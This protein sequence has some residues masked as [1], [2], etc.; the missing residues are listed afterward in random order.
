MTITRR[1]L[2][3][4]SIALF[5]LVVVSAFGLRSLGKAQTRFESVQTDTVP[6]IIDL[7]TIRNDFSSLRVNAYREFLAITDEQRAELNDSRQAI[8]QRLDRELAKYEATEISD[9][10][11][12]RMLQVDR[13]GLRAYETA[14]TTM[15]AKIHAGDTEAAKKLILPHGDMAEAA[16][17]LQKALSDHIDYNQKLGENLRQENT[18]AYTSTVTV[19]SCIVV[20][21]VLT[22]GAL[23]AQLYLIISRGLSGL[24]KTLED[25]SGS[26]DLT[27]TAPVVRMDEIGHTSVAF[28]AL[29]ARVA[30]VVGEVRQSSGSV[31]VASREI[32]A[33]NIDLSAR[34]E[35]Q[36]ASL[37]QTAA[38]M[39]QLT[40]TVKQNTDSAQMASKLAGDA[41]DVT[42]AGSG[43]VKRMVG[44]MNEITENSTKI[45]DITA[46]IE[47]IA[48]QTNILALNAAVEA[49][50]AGEQ[51]RGFAV[52]ASEV[53]TLAQRSSAAA[54]EIKDLIAVS[55]SVVHDGS[56]QAEEVGRV[57]VQVGEAVKRVADIIG[58]IA[59]ASNEQSRG[60]EQVNQAVAQMD[61]VTQQNAAL[62]EE[63]A[64]ATQSLQE[65]ANKMTD[66]VSAFRVGG[67]HHAY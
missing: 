13:D 5:A 44:T 21:A 64:A 8:V 29:L 54:K 31:A 27:H 32:A 45:G 41:S 66:T 36:A 10:T 40:A 37:Q 47:G 25:V 58:E 14:L 52:V 15:V 43:V 60:I 53:R 6:S 4:I 63:A 22:V 1:L 38:S 16:T 61:Q 51:G 49:A 67:M 24:Q 12:R 42:M 18:S 55:V 65:Q 48:F 7:S 46:L 23:A 30:G 9:D 59:S 19:L 3:I 33:G 50:R 20:L 34:T 11:D 39:E 26:L 17:A 35:E 28:N 2:V 62:V 57:T 56:R